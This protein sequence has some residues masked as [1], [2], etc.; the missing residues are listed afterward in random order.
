MPNL[1]ECCTQ[2]LATKSMIV[3][4]QSHLY[5]TFWTHKHV[6]LFEP[7]IGIFPNGNLL[8][9]SSRIWVLDLTVLRDQMVFNWIGKSQPLLRNYLWRRFDCIKQIRRN[10]FNP[11][12]GHHEV[13]LND[14]LI[15]EW[16]GVNENIHTIMLT[17]QRREMLQQINVYRFTVVAVFYNLWDIAF[18]DFVQFT[19]ELN[20]WLKRVGLLGKIVSQLTHNVLF[21][22]KVLG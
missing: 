22:T 3:G 21:I 11:E 10:L 4:K 12:L 14:A 2:C 8:W 16:L 13:F 15:L 6:V 17:E 7:H 18:M 19:W 1:C 9:R 20:A 5:N